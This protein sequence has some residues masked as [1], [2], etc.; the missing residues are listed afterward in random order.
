MKTQDK[1]K[2]SEDAKNKFP[3]ELIDYSKDHKFWITFFNGGSNVAH[4]GVPKEFTFKELPGIYNK[5]LLG[6]KHDAYLVRGKLNNG[7]RNDDN[8]EVSD[9][10]YIDGDHS[11][12]EA[13]MPPH[14]IGLSI[15]LRYL[16]ISHIIHSSYSFDSKKGKYKFRCIIPCIGMEKK[17]LKSTIM[18]LTKYLQDMAFPLL[19][20]K[21]MGT[22]SQPWYLPF[23]ENPDDGDFVYLEYL[24]G[25]AIVPVEVYPPGL[26]RPVAKVGG[27]GKTAS[28]SVHNI[29]LMSNKDMLASIEAD[30]EFHESFNNLVQQKAYDTEVRSEVLDRAIELLNMS[31]RS[32]DDY[33]EG[34]SKDRWNT[35]FNRVDENVDKAI[36]IANKRRKDD[37][38]SG[39]P[40]GFGAYSPPKWLWTHRIAE[41]GVSLLAAKQGTGKSALAAKIAALVSTGGALPMGEGDM[42]QGSVLWITA[43]ENPSSELQARLALNGADLNQ[44]KTLSPM[45]KID[46]KE[47]VLCLVDN[48]DYIDRCIREMDDCKLV[49]IDTIQSFMGKYNDNSN[50]D[51]KRLMAGLTQLSIKYGLGILGIAHV[52]KAFNNEMMLSITGANSFSSSP[53][54]VTGLVRDPFHEG[55]N[56]LCT[57]GVLKINNGPMLKPLSYDFTYETYLDDDL[58]T[59]PVIMWKTEYAEK[60]CDEINRNYESYKNKQSSGNKRIGEADV[61]ITIQK[62]MKHMG[63]PAKKST[64]KAACKKA[65]EKTGQD[66]SDKVF[67]KSINAMMT[68]SP[69]YVERCD[70]D[71]LP[72]GAKRSEFFYVLTKEGEDSFLDLAAFR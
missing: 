45:V 42:E 21:E 4:G 1:I 16:N 58:N 10:L 12:G 6:G 39:G 9:L 32:K 35:E 23:R 38:R 53:R 44:I 24:K 43:E 59:F 17:H 31:P 40:K 37:M 64:I 70:P 5:P 68:G 50:A 13:E 27:K 30:D 26:D 72:E 60:T 55:M 62:A 46:G 33:P 2:I 22:W 3:L 61:K 34:D 49:V 8:L 65:F 48:I 52:T 57:F 25:K 71:K 36:G 41:D 67:N 29:G 51:V 28:G 54:V 11:I 15:A 7:Y 18:L 14:P 20:V 66:M 19:Y 69:A 63:S 56:P 47:Q